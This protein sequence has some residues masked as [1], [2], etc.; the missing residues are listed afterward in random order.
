MIK[1]ADRARW[2]SLCTFG[3]RPGQLPFWEQ[4]FHRF[5][6]GL[7]IG[8]GFARLGVSTHRPD[9]EVSVGFRMCLSCSG[10]SLLLEA[11]ARRFGVVTSV[12]L[13]ELVEPKS[14]RGLSG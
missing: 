9:K 6:T 1:G 13:L 8:E 4:P 10:E 11:L 3:C 2:E 12:R 14:A 5:L 7:I